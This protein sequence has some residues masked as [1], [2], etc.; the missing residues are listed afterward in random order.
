MNVPYVRTSTLAVISLIF[1]ILCWVG[2]PFI[3]A[4]VAVICGHSARGEIRRAPPGSIDGDGMA[5]TGLILGWAHLIFI[6]ACVFVLFAFLG[7]LA[8]LI[9]LAHLVH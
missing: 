5:V 3:G 2:L 8:F 4:V 7:G 6:A 1:G 9:H